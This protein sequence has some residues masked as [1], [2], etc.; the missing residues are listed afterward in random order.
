MKKPCVIWEG[1]SEYGYPARAVFNGENVDFE[2]AEFLDAMG[3]PQWRRTGPAPKEFLL[4]AAQ[5]IMEVKDIR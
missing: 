1:E 3:A 4:K 2:I 5:A